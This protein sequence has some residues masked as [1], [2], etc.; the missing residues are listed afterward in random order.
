VRVIAATNRNLEVSIKE[1]RFREDLFY[2]LSVVDVTL[3]PLRER[4]EDILPLCQHFLAFFAR[5]MRRSLPTLSAETE[6]LLTNYHWPGNIRELRNT[7][8]RA[9]VF[10]TAQVLTPEVFPDRMQSLPT[11]RPEVG[12]NFTLDQIEREHIHRILAQ[13]ATQEEAAKILGIDTT[14]LW[15]KKKR[16]EEKNI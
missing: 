11:R 5:S 3:P 10:S 15:R 2:R 6:L 1:G 16:F 12:G 4:Q 14:T 7:I 13:S 8:E 9:L